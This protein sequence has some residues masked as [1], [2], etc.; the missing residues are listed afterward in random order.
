MKMS[1]SSGIFLFG[2]FRLDRAGGGLFRLDADGV[3][4]PVAIGSRA[5]EILGALVER[6]GDIVP[7]E[8]IIG[9]G[10]PRTVVAEGNLF[11]QIAALRRML[12]AAQSGQSCIQ[13]AIGRGY[14]FV[15][16]VTR[17]EPA[18]LRTSSSTSPNRDGGPETENERRASLAEALPAS[19]K[20][21][22]AVL[23]FA[24]L[25]AD[26][27]QEYFVDGMVEEIITAL[28]RIRW[29]CVLARNSSFTYKG[30]AIDVKRVGRELGVRYVLEGSV[31]K[32]G[33]R[34]RIAGQHID[35]PATS[36]R[37]FPPRCACATASLIA[38]R[39]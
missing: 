2:E 9:A 5:L 38:E 10:W 35:H 30:Q 28:S 22:I 1:A 21:S 26:P 3:F 13:T 20:P 34:V 31:R 19:D 17:V 25:S 14:R 33:N 15:A 8:E 27:E 16:P 11:V 6:R 37:I 18:S 29:L 7:K 24:N 32:A 39:G 23:P 12:D 36:R 4:V